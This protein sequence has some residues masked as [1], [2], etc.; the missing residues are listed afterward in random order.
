MGSIALVKGVS[1]NVL[2][3]LSDGQDWVWSADRAFDSMPTASDELPELTAIRHENRKHTRDREK[4]PA[5][6]SR[7][8]DD[9][10]VTENLTP[11]P[12]KSGRAP[13]PG[14]TGKTPPSQYSPLPPSSSNGS[15]SDASSNHATKWIRPRTPDGGNRRPLN[16]P[17]EDIQT[18]TSARELKRHR[19]PAMHRRLPPEDPYRHYGSRRSAPSYDHMVPRQYSGYP[20]L[21]RSSGYMQDYAVPRPSRLAGY[22]PRY[23]P[24]GWRPDEF[25]GDA[26]DDDMEIV[27][28]S[29]DAE[30]F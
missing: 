19:A 4:E 12:R 26:Y 23:V 7:R 27:P 8:D 3:R 30:I 5:S 11:R 6:R 24:R 28:P 2:R 20:P 29:D 1:G 22:G 10:R 9:D 14:P 13:P 21:H 17:R 25:Y 16:D 18:P 15:R